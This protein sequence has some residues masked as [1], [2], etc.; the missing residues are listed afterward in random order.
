MEKQRLFCLGC[1]Y[2]LGKEKIDYFNK[3]ATAKNKLI[4]SENAT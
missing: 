3:V 1:N 2:I 4:R